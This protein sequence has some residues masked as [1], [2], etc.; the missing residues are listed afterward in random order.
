M[1]S[2]NKS[3]KVLIA[4]SSRDDL[5]EKLK[6]SETKSNTMKYQFD[7]MNSK[8]EEWRT[9]YD[10]LNTRLTEMDKIESK[11]KSNSID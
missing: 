6:Q 8:F 5:E 7:G 2:L 11:I 4:K 3:I 9:R 10:E 1:I